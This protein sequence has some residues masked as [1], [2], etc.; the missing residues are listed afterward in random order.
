MLV[1]PTHTG[2]LEEEKITE[3]QLDVYNYTSTHSNMLH[4]FT[5]DQLS[6]PSR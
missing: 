6:S 3:Q 2:Y 5:A 4:V 1:P